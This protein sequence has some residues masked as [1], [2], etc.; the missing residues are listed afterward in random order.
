R[1]DG[2]SGAGFRARL[3]AVAEALKKLPSLGSSESPTLA[4]DYSKRPKAPVFA[5]RDL[6]GRTFDLAAQR[7]HV[8][9][10]G[11]FDP[12]CPHCQRDLPRLAPVFREFRDRGVR[13][14]GVSSRDLHGQMRAFLRSM[15]LDIPVIIDPDRSLFNRFA[16][17]RT[18]DTFVIDGDGFVRFRGHGD[19]PDRPERTRLQLAL[20]LGKEKP[21]AL[22]AAL[23]KGRYVG[24]AICASCHER[25]HDDWLLTPHSIAWDSLAKGD[26]WKDPE[27][28]RCHVTGYKQP[29]GFD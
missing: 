7:G 2:F 11:F 5:A 24:D 16:S 21:Q 4:I 12:E 22:A 20:A 15:N 26:K 29:G 1:L 9:V 25:E 14:V 17:T 23:P 19:R 28:V 18:P 3:A 6:D 8:G 13:A 27:C 10:V